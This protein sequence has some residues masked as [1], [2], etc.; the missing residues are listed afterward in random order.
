MDKQNKRNN[1]AGRYTEWV[2]VVIKSFT[3]VLN[4]KGQG[5]IV[6]GRRNIAVNITKKF[7]KIDQKV[8]GTYF[9]SL[10]DDFHFFI[11]FWKKLRTIY[12]C[13]KNA[14]CIISIN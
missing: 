8:K 4:V 1:H 9:F 12:H 11:I 13:V 3:S 10:F 14:Q 2:R 7:P 5:F 6:L